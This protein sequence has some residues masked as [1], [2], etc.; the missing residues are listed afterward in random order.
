MSCSMSLP[1]G[2]RWEFQVQYEVPS[3]GMDISGTR[4]FTRGGGYTEKVFSKTETVHFAW[5]WSFSW[6][7]PSHFMCFAF[8]TSPHDRLMKLCFT[9]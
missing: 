6:R 4:S 1:G 9:T 3:K 5:I 8:S 7:L 2:Q